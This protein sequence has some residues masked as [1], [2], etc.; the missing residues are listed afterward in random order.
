M[1]QKFIIICLIIF[2][3][4]TVRIE[5]IIPSEHVRINMHYFQASID[6]VKVRDHLTHSILMP[7]PFPNIHLFVYSQVVGQLPIPSLSITIK[8]LQANV[9]SLI[10]HPSKISGLPL[11]FYGCPKVASLQAV[12]ARSVP[13]YKCTP[14]KKKSRSSVEDA[15]GEELPTAQAQHREEFLDTS[16]SINAAICDCKQL[17]FY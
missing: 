10:R 4:G 8:M 15:N 12:R 5:T 3:A 14:P 13:S 7:I 6:I 9:T 11:C 17:L 16:T 1:S 2:T